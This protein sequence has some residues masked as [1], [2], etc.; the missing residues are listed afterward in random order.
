MRAQTANERVAR[1]ERMQLQLGVVLPQGDVVWIEQMRLKHHVKSR[2]HG[3]TVR[4]E[5]GARG[6]STHANRVENRK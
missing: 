6:N 1:G 2:L 3:Q 4:D 5:K